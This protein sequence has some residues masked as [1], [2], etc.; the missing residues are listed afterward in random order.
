MALKPD[1]DLI[2]KMYST[3]LAAADQMILEKNKKI[4]S[5]EEEVTRLRELLNLTKQ[6]RFGSSSEVSKEIIPSDNTD[7]IV[8]TIDV[9]AHQRKQKRKRKRKGRLL[10]FE[11]LPC[12]QRHYDLLDQEKSCQTCTH[13]LHLIKKTSTKQLE[14]IPVRYCVVEHVQYTYGCRHC[15]R[16]VTPTKPPP[17]IPKAMAGASLL[18][19]VVI[20]KYQFHQPLYRQSKQMKNDHLI[21]PDN[22]LGNWMVNIGK[23]L[24][25]LYDAMWCILKQ[26]YL[27]VDETP[28]KILEPNKQGYLWTYYAPYSRNPSTV[29]DPGGLIVFELSETRAGKVANDRLQP[30]NGLLQTDGYSGYQSLRNRQGIVGLG[31]L[32]HCRRKFN[33]VIKIS[34]DDQGIAAQMIEKM[35]PLYQLEKRMQQLNVSFHTRKRLRQKIARPITQDIFR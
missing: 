30:F 34:K 29:R 10:S 20:N 23:A 24:K 14:I 5:L 4:T 25:P 19:D 33:E 3:A 27:Q 31:C 16:V 13:A 6:Q 2:V 1:I 12:L 15:N 7:E 17:P 11:N 9:A 35:K 18:A 8:D 32:T 26:R 22:T 21:I 28:V